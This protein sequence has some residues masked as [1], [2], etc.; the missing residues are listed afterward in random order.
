[1]LD[2]SADSNVNL[3]RHWV[4]PF[5][6]HVCEDENILL[7]FITSHTERILPSLMIVCGSMSFIVIW[8]PIELYSELIHVHM[9]STFWSF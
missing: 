7:A 3:A 8:S 5:T 4:T 9:H 6:L 2:S 1:M